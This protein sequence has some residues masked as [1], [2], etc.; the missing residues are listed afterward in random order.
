MFS[1]EKVFVTE[2]FMDTKRVTVNDFFTV[3]LIFLVNDRADVFY[4]ISSFV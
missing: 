2:F 4:F 3:T 1:D